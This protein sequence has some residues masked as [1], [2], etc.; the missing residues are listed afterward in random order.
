MGLKAPLNKYK[1]N[2]DEEDGHDYL[3]DDEDAELIMKR[4]L[5]MYLEDLG[6]VFF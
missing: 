2:G 5:A 3:G 4:A 1:N 6:L